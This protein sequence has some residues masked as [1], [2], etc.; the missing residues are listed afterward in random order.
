MYVHMIVDMYICTYD[1]RYVCMYI[2]TYIS[3]YIRMYNFKPR[4]EEFYTFYD[5]QGLKWSKVRTCLCMCVHIH[6][7]CSCFMVCMHRA[8]I[9]IMYYYVCMYCIIINFRMYLYPLLL[10][11][12]Y[13][14][15]Y[16]HM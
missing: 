14:H 8:N 3:T 6:Y 16:V 10:L 2:R 12:M 7:F 15:T 11:N 1:C 9:T 5:T 13:V 4:L